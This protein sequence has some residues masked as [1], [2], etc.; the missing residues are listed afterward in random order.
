MLPQSPY[1]PDL[2]VLTTRAATRMW[3]VYPGYVE[4]R[5]SYAELIPSVR[6]NLELA[7]RVAHRGGGP[8]EE[9]RRPARELGARRANQEVPLESIIQAY[10]QTE[11]VLVLDLVAHAG[12]A[13]ET[14]A[15]LV[16]SCFDALTDAMINSYWDTS[17]AIEAERRRVADELVTSLARGLD[18]SPARF[19]RWA[20]TLGIGTHGR[21]IAAAVRDRGEAGAQTLQRRLPRL[22]RGRFRHIVMADVEDALLILAC[23][24]AGDDEAR[25]GLRAVLTTASGAVPLICGIGDAADSLAASTGSCRQALEAVQVAA[26]RADGPVTVVEY[27][28]ALVDIMLG[29]HIVAADALYDAVIGPL[30]SRPY[31]IETL[32][33]LLAENLSQSA[34]ARALYLHPNTVNHRVRRIQELTGR[35]PTTFPDI[36]EI[37]LAL[38]RRRLRAHREHTA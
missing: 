35:N 5:F 34:T 2:D 31:L 12:A 14:Y 28:E 37:A 29:G 6:E 13:A 32:E 17:S 7:V 38:R 3:H 11:R 19:D 25:A 30:L 8:T 4:E 23:H 20:R 21:W 10:R 27:R 24:S 36:V 33:T 22:W 16:I 1:S 18:V 15:D 26:T 9:E